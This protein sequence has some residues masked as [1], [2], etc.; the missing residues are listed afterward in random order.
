MMLGTYTKL[1]FT[2]LNYNLKYT[3]AA[4]A[5]GELTGL[6]PINQFKLTGPKMRPRILSFKQL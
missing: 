3:L 2:N 5:L 4:A 1:K 6:F